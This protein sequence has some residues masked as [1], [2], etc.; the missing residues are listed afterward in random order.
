MG[1]GP[2]AGSVEGGVQAVRDL[3]ELLYPERAE[4]EVLDLVGSTARALLTAK[5]ALS[6]ENIQRFWI[7]SE[8]RDWILARAKDPLRG[9][10][11]AHRGQGVDPESLNPD[12]GWLIRDRLSATEHFFADADGPDEDH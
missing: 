2:K 5:A 11:D 4:A 12:F 1:F 10:W 8:W 7:D 9:P 3:I 6:F